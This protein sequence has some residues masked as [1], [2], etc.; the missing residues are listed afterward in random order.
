MLRHNAVLFGVDTQGAELQD[1]EG[2][3]VLNELHDKQQREIMRRAGLLPADHYDSIET[4]DA[5]QLRKELPIS[6]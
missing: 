2:L 1:L 6:L 3:S 4:R 5:E